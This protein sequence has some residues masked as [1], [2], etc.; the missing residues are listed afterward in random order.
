MLH[1]FIFQDFTLIRKTFFA[2]SISITQTVITR[3]KQLVIMQCPYYFYSFLMRNFC[4]NRRELRMNIIQMNN[5]RQ[6]SSNNAVNLRFTSFV[7]KGRNNA[8]SIPNPGLN[9]TSPGKYLL[10]GVSILSGYCMAK[11]ATSWP[12]RFNNSSRFMVQTQSPPRR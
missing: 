3:T 6:K 9:F 8:S 10:H 5:I 7:P 12:F 4:N 2:Y 11:I 1:T